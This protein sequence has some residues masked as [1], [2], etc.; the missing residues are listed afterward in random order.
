MAKG[1]LPKEIEPLRL[2]DKGVVLQGSLSFQKMPRLLEVV[3]NAIGEIYITLHFLKDEQGIRSI[4]G[5]LQT[6]LTLACQRCLQPVTYPMDLV[7]RIRP[8]AS[9]SAIGNMPN[10]YD[11]L[12]VT[13]KPMRLAEVIEEE[14]LLNLPIVAKHNTGKCPVKLE[15]DYS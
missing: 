13:S 1:Q 5:K 12:L 2:A 14:I 4:C 3:V 8:V 11:P 10:D 6:T 15:W 9:E 7:V